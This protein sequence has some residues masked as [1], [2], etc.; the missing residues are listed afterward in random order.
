VSRWFRMYD[1]I[2]DDPKVQKLP[3]ELF[4]AWVNALALCSR[5]DGRLPSVSDCA[6]AFRETEASVSSAFH[7]FTELGLFVTVDETFQPKNWKKRQ[8]KSD[9]STGRVRAYRKRSR[10]GDETAPDT[11]TDTEKE[12][13]VITPPKGGQQLAFVGKVIRLSHSD[14]GNWR[15]AYPAIDLLAALQS[16]DDWLATEADEK[17]RKKWFLSTSN[18][19]ANLQQKAR[20][21]DRAPVWDGM[22]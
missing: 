21:I 13:K 16:R 17:T 6:F 1:E 4:R 7:T 8:Y 3:P 19:L 14:F 12:K 15:I 11:E 2:L 18:H 5:N 22:P 10:N 9:T 20:A